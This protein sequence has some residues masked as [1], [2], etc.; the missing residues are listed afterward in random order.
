MALE[1]CSPSQHRWCLSSML[2]RAKIMVAGSTPYVG[3][4]RESPTF[5]TRM[6]RG[7]SDRLTMIAAIASLVGKSQGQTTRRRPFCSRK[8]RRT[9]TLDQHRLVHVRRRPPNK[10]GSDKL[11][12]ARVTG[13]QDQKSRHHLPVRVSD[14]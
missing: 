1:L 8:V 6:T 5:T 11:P 14:L 13:G 7:H 4:M 2:E 12:S 10:P 3:L 9:R